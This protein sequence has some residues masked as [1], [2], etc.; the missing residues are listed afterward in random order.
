MSVYNRK[1]FRKKGGGS[2]GI[3]AS[4]PELIKAQTGVSVNLGGG[5]SKTRGGFPSIGAFSA[6]EPPIVQS[7]LGAISLSPMGADLQSGRIDILGQDR[8]RFG[9]TA[10]EQLAQ[11]EANVAGQIGPFPKNLSASQKLPAPE[12]KTTSYSE[13]YKSGFRDLGSGINKSIADITSMTGVDQYD[14]LNTDYDIEKKKDEKDSTVTKNKTKITS[15]NIKSPSEADDLIKKLN[16]SPTSDNKG[17]GVEVKGKTK[18]NVNTTENKTKYNNY[19]A[20]MKEYLDK[21]DGENAANATLKAHGFKDNDIKDLSPKE[22]V[23]EVKNIITE[24]MG[25]KDP[26]RDMGLEDDLNAMNIVMLGLSIAAGDSPDALT[27]IAKGAKE[28]VLRRSKQIK[29]KRDEERQLDLLALKTVLGREDKKEDQKFQK[30]MAADGRKHDLTLFSKKNVFE[31]SK[32]AKQHNFQDHI[33]TV[34]NN[35]KLKLDDNQ[36]LR[37]SQS[38]K[39]QIITLTETLKNKTEI[40]NAQLQQSGDI[41][42]MNKETKLLIAENQ[43]ESQELR[44]IIGNLPEGYGFAMIEGKKKGL[45]GDKLVNYAKEKGKVF[46]KNP[47]LT[48]PDSFRRMVINVVPKIMKEDGV[49]FDKALEN[50]SKSIQGNDEILKYFPELQQEKINNIIKNV[51]NKPKTVT[52]LGLNVNPGDVLGQDGKPYTGTGPKFIVQNDGTV[53]KG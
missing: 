8:T 46:A 10:L 40:A 45:E 47:Y 9:K 12:D 21:G 23:D 13:A 11:N 17:D 26:S 5:A 22:K 1:M 29:E 7:G 32:L 38:L 14:E 27:N 48:G 2:I 28:H 6:Y 51:Q 4:G 33:N 42:N 44:T 18:G 31:M 37:H 39:A 50:L 19:S 20:I 16:I 25:G 36:T 49:T 35:L 43:L 24:V 41:A 15:P 34:N 3:M 52:D 30:E 53:V